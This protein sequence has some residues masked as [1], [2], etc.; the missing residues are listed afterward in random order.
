MIAAP[1]ETR[2]PRKDRE[3]RFYEAVTEALSDCR[4]SPDP[5]KTLVE[6]LEENIRA[7]E[8]AFALELL[9]AFVK[10]SPERIEG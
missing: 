4:V 9:T 7:D 2:Q 6:V 1:D 10:P 8:G 3:M 5:I